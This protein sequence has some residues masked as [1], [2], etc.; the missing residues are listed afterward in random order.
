MVGVNKYAE[1][2]EKPINILRISRR[3]QKS[4]LSKLL[5]VKQERNEKKVMEALSELEN[6]LRNPEENSM[7]Y[8]IRA[9]ESYATLE[10]ISNV[11]RNVFG[12]WKE[13]VLV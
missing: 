6:A 12:G 3:A 1:S 13:P 2:N 5:S 7:P 4:Q 8:I 10:E 11:G 9:V